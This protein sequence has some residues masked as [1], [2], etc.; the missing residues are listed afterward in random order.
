MKKLFLFLGFILASQQC[1]ANDI[2]LYE[3]SQNSVVI[4]GYLAGYA[5]Y[6][7]IKRIN[8]NRKKRTNIL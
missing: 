4:D 5:V 8:K 2:T 7:D 3:D 1:F 6:N